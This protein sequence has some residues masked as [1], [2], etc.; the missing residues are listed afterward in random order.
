MADPNT[1]HSC[2]DRRPSPGPVAVVCALAVAVAF[3]AGGPVAGQPPTAR[4]L[5]D[6]ARAREAAIRNT[7]AHPERSLPDPT[8]ESYQQAMGAY[9]SVALRYPTSGY[10]DDALW[11]GAQ[12]AAESSVRFG[13]AED[14]RTAIGLYDRLSAEYPAS[15]FAA[16]ARA[17]S[18][19]LGAQD[20]RPGSSPSSPPAT[21]PAGVP[22]PAAMAAPP[23]GPTPSA[24]PG[25]SAPLVT[26]RDIRRRTTTDGMEVEVETDGPVVYRTGRLDTPPRVF[27]DLLATQITSALRDAMLTFETGLVRQVRVGRPAPQT[28]RVVI[29]TAS[30]VACDARKAVDPHRI[31][32][33]CRDRAASTP[34]PARGAA[35]PAPPPPAAAATPTTAPATQESPPAPVI[36]SSAPVTH[37][38]PGAASTPPSATA[39]RQAR[40]GTDS[41]PAP[42]STNASGGFSMA[43]QL[44]LRVG[45]I[46]ID[47]GHGGRDPGALGQGTSEAAITLDVALRLEKLLAREPGVDVVLTRRTD[48]FV[49]LQERPA[50]A[51][52]EHA[53]LFVSIHVNANRDPSVRGVETYLLNFASTPDAA[54]VAARENASSSLT[55][56]H[57]NDLVKQ[58]ALGSKLQESNDLA[59]HMQG[60]LVKK[61]RPANQ[62]V[63]DLGV[64]QAPFVVL[65]GASMPSV[66]VEVAFITH[67][68]EGRLIATGA[69]R[70]TIAESLLDGVRQYLR[71]LK[72]AEALA[73]Q[74]AARGA[75][76]VR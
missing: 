36:L 76:P 67:A 29:E 3:A 34:P 53:D 5:F 30:D 44:G 37:A 16:E 21:P 6:A 50:I 62:P 52:R 72:R 68:Q 17:Q 54:A 59:G 13:A 63:R 60:A 74:G 20:G 43:R 41:R 35:R 49:A 18:A 75:T 31:V 66:L 24:E 57:L 23:A 2:R 4:E 46:V 51:N 25:G 45:R 65:V 8:R 26:V 28:T 55:M 19:R 32:V 11:Y 42:P 40:P 12:L 33:S 9:R 22:S 48:E 15:P 58:I 1:A 7:L 69:Y 64:K 71:T 27:L 14:R 56:S 10:G 38:T 70:Q 73:D 61:L 47:P 39:A